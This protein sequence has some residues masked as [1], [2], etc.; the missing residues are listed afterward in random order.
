MIPFRGGNPVKTR[1][2]EFDRVLVISNE[3]VL[4]AA[5]VDGSLLF[6]DFIDRADVP[7]TA[8]DLLDQIAAGT[9]VIDAAS[10][11]DR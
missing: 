11:C 10:R 5:E 9:V 7:I 4:A 3:A 8:S 2:V 1:A 6:V